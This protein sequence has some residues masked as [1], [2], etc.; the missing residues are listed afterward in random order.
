MPTNLYRFSLFASSLLIAF[1]GTLSTAHA[2][3]ASKDSGLDTTVVIDAGHGGYDRGGIPGQ[4]VAEKEMTLDVA[5]R[6][7]KVLAASGYRVVMTR[8]SDVFVPLGTRVAI[9]NSYANAIFVSVHFNS[10]KRSGASGIETYFYDRE[11]LPLASAI[12]YFVA[13]GAASSNRNVRRR[14]YYVLRKNRNPAVL[15]ECGFLPTRAK[16]RWRKAL[17]TVKSSQKKL[18]PA[19]AAAA[20]SRARARQREWRRVKAFRCNRT[21]IKP[22][23]RNQR[24]VGPSVHTKRARGG[25][26]AHRN[27]A[28]QKQKRLQKVRRD[29]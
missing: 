6:L 13:G 28:G 14:G 19:S 11:S 10:A 22:E 15:V 29:D 17:L 1:L 4:R 9:A 20:P 16:Q 8:D 27:Q 18:Q 24:A 2:R 5:Q 21:S 25:R 3:R 26:K 12:H 7:K 23:L